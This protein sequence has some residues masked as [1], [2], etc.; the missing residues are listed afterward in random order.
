MI[1]TQ[2]QLTEEQSENLKRLAKSEV[3]GK[4]AP[5]LQLDAF[6]P[7]KSQICCLTVSNPGSREPVKQLERFFLPS[8]LPIFHAFAVKINF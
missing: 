5:L 3:A 2:I 4:N 6:T 1:R 7:D 8:G